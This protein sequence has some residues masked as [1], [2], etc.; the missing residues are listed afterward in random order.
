MRTL[1]R[2]LHRVW[3]PKRRPA[4]LAQ[5]VR[6]RAAAPATRLFRYEPSGSFSPAAWRDEKLRILAPSAPLPQRTLR[7][8]VVVFD[9]PLDE[10]AKAKLAELAMNDVPLLIGPRSEPSDFVWELKSAVLARGG[11]LE[12]ALARTDFPRRLEAI[13][14]GAERRQRIPACEQREATRSR[15]RK[16]MVQLR[17][18]RRLAA[19]ELGQRAASVPSEPALRGLRSPRGR[20]D[21][22]NIRQLFGFTRAEFAR[23]LSVPSESMRMTPDS[24]TLQDKLRPYEGIARMLAVIPDPADFR[25]WLQRPDA[26]LEGRSPLETIST[27]GPDEVAAWVA[28]Q[29]AARQAPVPEAP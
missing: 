20:L 23:R 8:C 11:I 24:T 18:K 3:F 27:D 21:A 28:D 12:I 19:V 7:D 1:K 29:L 17:R 14:K 4:K 22:D 15:V 25:H 2:L 5:T 9:A 13:L 16:R 6:I 26:G 10:R